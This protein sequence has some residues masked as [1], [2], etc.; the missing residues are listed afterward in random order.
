MNIA[1]SF[2]GKMPSY[3]FE[4]VAQTRLF[5]KGDIYIIYNIIDAELME[6]LA[7]HRIIFVHYDLIVSKRF[8]EKFNVSHFHFCDRLE[9]RELLFLR[10][11]ER[12]YLLDEMMKLYNLRNVWFM[13]I[14]NL[15]YVDPSKFLPVLETKPCVYSYHNKGSFSTGVFFIRSTDDFQPVLESLDNFS[16]GFRSEMGSFHYHYF[17]SAKKDCL[18]PLIMPVDEVNSLYYKNFSDF[19]NY[20]FDGAIMGMYYFGIDSYH[21]NGKLEIKNPLAYDIKHKYLNVWKYGDL[22]WKKNED[23]LF[24]P[25]YITMDDVELPVANLHIHSKN[26]IAAVSY[27]EKS[28]TYE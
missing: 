7:V 4:C 14:D 3:I 22:K 18:F 19:D 12:F 9:G 23:G 21:T 11:Y 15:L 26:L 13:E 27:T 24:L 10:S 1:L 8:N 20:I 28:D 16:D 25:Y 2:I 5:F 17:R 6:K